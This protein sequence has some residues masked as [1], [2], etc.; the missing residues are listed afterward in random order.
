MVRMRC[1]PTIQVDLC[2]GTHY[3]NLTGP[4]WELFKQGFD[5]CYNETGRSTVLSVEYCMDL[6][7]CGQYIAEWANM[8]RTSPDIQATWDS[9]LLNSDRKQALLKFAASQHGV[10]TPYLTEHKLL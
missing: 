1:N 5:K 9:I 4:S 7:T 10:C 2:G 6:S 8:W 3:Q